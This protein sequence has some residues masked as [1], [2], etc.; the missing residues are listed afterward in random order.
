MVEGDLEI[1]VPNR[2]QE[3]AVDLVLLV[4]YLIL[5]LTWSF[6]FLAEPAGLFLCLPPWKYGFA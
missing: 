1:R 6:K 3:N 2:S 4:R 5:S